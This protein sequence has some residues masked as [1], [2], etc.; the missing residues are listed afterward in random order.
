MTHANQ[1]LQ[2]LTEAR[3]HEAATHLHIVILV[4]LHTQHQH[5]FKHVVTAIQFLSLIP[6]PL[7]HMRRLR[8]HERL[9][10]HRHRLA[11]N[12]DAVRGRHGE[13]A[14]AHVR[15]LRLR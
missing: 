5:V 1:R 14:L 3:R 13:H 15:V 11:G 9:H 7:T 8:V 6:S 12:H 2:R 4:V 10:T